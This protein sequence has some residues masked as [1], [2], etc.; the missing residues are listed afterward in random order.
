MR[1]R[2]RYV[3]SLSFLFKYKWI[4]PL[5]LVLAVAGIY[6]GVEKTPTGFV[7]NEDRGVLFANVE[8]PAQTTLDRTVAIHEPTRKQKP[9]KLMG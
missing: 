2:P 7:P 4:T 1:L 5:I 3:N 6:I 9:I 8:L